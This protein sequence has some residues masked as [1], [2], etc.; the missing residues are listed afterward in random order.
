MCLVNTEPEG[1]WKSEKWSATNW[2][3]SAG[4]GQSAPTKT[5]TNAEESRNARRPARWT[6]SIAV[7]NGVTGT[8]TNYGGVNAPK[9]NS[10]SPRDAGQYA[11]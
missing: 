2:F 1:V 5:Q 8:A 3:I 7:V 6:V 4:H 10:N 9:L 11:Q